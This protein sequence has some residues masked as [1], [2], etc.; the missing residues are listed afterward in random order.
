MSMVLGVLREIGYEELAARMR[1]G[2]PRILLRSVD[3]TDILDLEEFRGLVP[4]NDIRAVLL[5]QLWKQEAAHRFPSSRSP[6]PHKSREKDPSLYR[7]FERD[8]RLW[9]GT[10]VAP[11]VIRREWGWVDTNSRLGGATFEKI[12]R[13]APA[14]G[15][16]QGVRVRVVE[17]DSRAWAN[18]LRPGDISPR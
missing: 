13:D 3:D 15:E 14:Y 11:S 9:L 17:R 16:V 10:T 12:P 1:M 8:V 18:G 4:D 7:G 5:S 6:N 2:V